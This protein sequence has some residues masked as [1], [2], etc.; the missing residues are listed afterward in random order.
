MT[1]FDKIN[2]DL[3]SAMLAKD[4]GALRAI[5][6]IKAALLL[7]KT[8]TGKDITQE[9]EIKILQRLAKQRRE[10]IEIFSSNNR[11]DLAFTEKEELDIIEKYLPQ[12]ISPDILRQELNLIIAEVGARSPADLGKVMGIASKKL[13]GRSDGKK[14]SEMVKQLLSAI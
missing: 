10:S 5:R 6:A 3:K 7:A 2:E 1:L 13:A 8:E 9:D 14:I 11:E 12:Q 4:Q